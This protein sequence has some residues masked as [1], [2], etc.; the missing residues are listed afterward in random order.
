MKRTQ[1]IVAHIGVALM[2]SSLTA[3]A[4]AQAVRCRTHYGGSWNASLLT[5]C[6]LPVEE[7]VIAD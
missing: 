4:I 3:N 6:E 5:R 1:T 2:D 7:V